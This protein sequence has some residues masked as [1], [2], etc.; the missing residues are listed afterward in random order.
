MGRCLF[1]HGPALAT[2]SPPP[3]PHPEAEL[4]G[5][6]R[7]VKQLRATVARLLGER[8]PPGTLLPTPTFARSGSKHADI[9]KN[10]EIRDHTQY[11]HWTGRHAGAAVAGCAHEPLLL[12]NTFAALE[13]TAEEAQDGKHM[14]EDHRKHSQVRGEASNCKVHFNRRGNHVCKGNRGEASRKGGDVNDSL[15]HIASYHDAGKQVIPQRLE[16]K[17][18]QLPEGYIDTA[19]NKL[20]HIQ[21][22]Y[23]LSSMDEDEKVPNSRGDDEDGPA[24][25]E[26]FSDE[27]LAYSTAFYDNHGVGKNG[28]QE[29]EYENSEAA[30]SFDQYNSNSSDLY[31]LSSGGVA[32]QDMENCVD[33]EGINS[34]FM[35]REMMRAACDAERRARVALAHLRARDAADKAACSAVRLRTDHCLDV[36]MRSKRS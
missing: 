3:A 31:D 34:G 8:A 28:W 12:S 15:S 35:N 27:D 14:H 26:A 6:R 20:F 16:D 22:S 11:R 36:E 25:Y 9:K 24:N 1:A 19:G 18:Y 10:N 33:D 4:I 13:E 17:T 30:T 29:Y 7:R 32:K 21:E 5:L 2:A 23:S